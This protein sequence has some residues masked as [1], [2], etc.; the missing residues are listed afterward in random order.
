MIDGKNTTV[1][2]NNTTLIGNSTP[3]ARISW[4]N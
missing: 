2:P 1:Q 4:I 3:Y